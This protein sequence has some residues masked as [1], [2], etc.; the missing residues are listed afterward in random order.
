MSHSDETLL[1]DW[2]WSAIPP[3][4]HSV[5]GNRRKLL[6]VCL[7]NRTQTSTKRE[8]KLMRRLK[9]PLERRQHAVR[10]FFSGSAALKIKNI[11]DLWQKV[12]RRLEILHRAEMMK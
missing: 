5:R 8:L 2:T 6:V 1:S 9:L 12:T 11:A 7:S 4:C 3:C 10:S